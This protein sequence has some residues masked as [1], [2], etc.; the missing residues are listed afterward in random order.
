MINTATPAS[1]PLSAATRPR[2]PY[3]SGKPRCEKERQGEVANPQGLPCQR[4]RQAQE[5]GLGGG[6]GGRPGV[7]G[8]ARHQRAHDDDG[9]TGPSAGGRRWPGRPER[10][11]GR[12][13]RTRGWKSRRCPPLPRPP[14]MARACPPDGARATRPSARQ[15]ASAAKAGTSVMNV[16]V[17]TTNPG[18]ART[19]STTAADADRPRNE[20]ATR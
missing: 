10:S 15:A 16:E 8:A 2:P 11:G 1:A 12:P 13:S 19:V 9:S 17:L 6:K 3:C 4:R 18:K 14:P 20:R 5:P 7:D